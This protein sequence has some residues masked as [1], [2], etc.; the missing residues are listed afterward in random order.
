MVETFVQTNA[1]TICRPWGD[2][3]WNTSLALRHAV[4]DAIRPGG[5]VIVDLSRVT[6]ID[7][8]GLSTVVGCLRRARAVGASI[9]IRNA[10][11]PV[12]ARLDLV[13]VGR[14]IQVVAIDGHDVA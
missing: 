10:R 1:G 7:A 11:P 6:A 5:A 14:D 8:V 4:H 2:L 13:I 9:L 12:Q 3:N